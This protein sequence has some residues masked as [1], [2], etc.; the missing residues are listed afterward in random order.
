MLH[1]PF[2]ITIIGNMILVNNV[3]PWT[4]STKEKNDSS[5]SWATYQSC[6]ERRYKIFKNKFSK[7]FSMGCQKPLS[8]FEIWKEGRF[9]PVWSDIFAC[10]KSVSFPLF[11]DLIS[12]FIA[13]QER[14]DINQ[15]P[16]CFHCI[17]LT[18]LIVCKLIRYCVPSALNGLK[19][20]FNIKKWE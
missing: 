16:D 8:I 7:K 9:F 11:L 6:L 15:K 10:Q 12:S 3:I 18:K 20:F 5:F 14:S 2:V 13:R 19:S 17:V 1:P 4:L